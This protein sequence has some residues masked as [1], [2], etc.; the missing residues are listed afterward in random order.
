MVVG[1]TQTFA[2]KNSLIFPSFA[3]DKNSPPFLLLS[4][5]KQTFSMVTT[6]AIRRRRNGANPPYVTRPRRN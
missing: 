1:V 6:G 4:I 2:R 5:N 3:R